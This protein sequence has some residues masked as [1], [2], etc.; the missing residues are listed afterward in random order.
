MDI[1][2]LTPPTPP[3][4]KSRNVSAAYTGG[5]G[6]VTNQRR[7]KTT[8]AD[9][10]T[11]A[12]LSAPTKSLAL[13]EINEWMAV[14]VPGLKDQKFLHSSQGWKVCGIFFGN[15]PFVTN[16]VNRSF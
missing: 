12:I 9:W 2:K 8:Y 15:V 16:Y 4:L 7:L 14:N 13:A 3:A 10:I 11:K 1:E 5:V 6:P